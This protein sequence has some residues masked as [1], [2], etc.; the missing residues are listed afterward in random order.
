MKI[1]IVGGGTLGH[2]IPGLILGNKLQDKHEIIYITTTKDKRFNVFKMH[3]YL[4]NVYYIDSSGFT[5]NIISNIKIIFKD[6]KAMKQIKKIINDESIELIIG[7]GGYISGLTMLCTKRK[8]RKIIHEQ[9]KVMGLAN[10]VSIPVVNK[11][12]LSFDIDLKKNNNKKAIVSNPCLFINK[13]NIQKEENHILI[14]SGSNGAKEIN[15]LAIKIINNRLIPNY[16]ITLVTG[17]KYY[18]E[19]IKKINNKQNIDIYPF[20]DNMHEYI[21]KASFIISRAGSST[22]FESLALETI[23]LLFPSSNV[24]NNHQYYNAMEIVNLGMGEIINQDN[25]IRTFNKIKN[26]YNSYLEN[27]RKY[28]KEYNL[29]KIINLIEEDNISIN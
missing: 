19:V 7:M 20:I 12:L 22:I 26:H 9:N 1:A 18:D 27:I 17:R 13:P 14:T 28:K 10:K 21:Y 25:V 15:D 8:I 16:H 29:N 5:K 3:T 23:P 4:K 2:I 11:V 24:T 6:L